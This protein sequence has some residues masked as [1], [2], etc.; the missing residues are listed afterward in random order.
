MASWNWPVILSTA[1]FALTFAGILAERVHRTL[2]ALCGAI[3]MVAIGGWFS[4]YGTHEATEAVDPNTIALL[5]GMMILVSLFRRTGVFE[6][7]AI[8]ATKRA[9]GRPILLFIY[10]GL[11]TSIV[12]M[13]LDNVTTIML[14]IPV[15]LS[16][17]DIIGLHPL[18]FL[19][20]EAMLSNIGGVATLIGD[21]PNILIGSA[22]RL[23]FLDFVIHLGPIV[24]VVWCVG[25]LVLLLRF[26]G[27][28]AAPPRT[29]DHLM[30]LDPHRAISDRRAA[31]RMLIALAGTVVLFLVHDL[32]GLESGVVA[33]IG[34]GGAMLSLWP[35]ISETLRDVHWDVLLFFIALF[36]LVGGLDAAGTLD[37][38]ADAIAHLAGGGIVLAALAVL[39]TSALMSSLVDNVPFTIAM[40][41][42]LTGLAARGIAVGPLWWAL[43]LGVG[44][45]GNATPIGAT[46]NVIAVSVSKKT[47]EPISTRR[48]IAAGIPLT[49]VACAIASLFLAGGIWIGFLR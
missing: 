32:L 11:A 2:V 31:R 36:V 25:L 35:D 20:G 7:V 5:L 3:L 39:W 29:V 48:W 10:L 46:A 49:L 38:I 30:K 8:R 44:F 28:L 34:A 17:T 22:A 9:R 45:G 16:I 43:A 1:I 24:V 26:R 37:A 47:D 6:S 40:L 21:P 27:P 18:P 13:F 15:T 41:P 14:M 19:I 33:L 42:V 4:F 23:T 12:S